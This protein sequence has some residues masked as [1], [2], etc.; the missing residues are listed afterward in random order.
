MLLM[1]AMAA[2]SFG[3]ITI[4][5]NVRDGQTISGIQAIRATV[6]SKHLITEVEFY[7]N[8]DLRSTDDSTPYE[9]QIDTIAE[10]EGP[11]K[12]KL[13]AFDTEGNRKELSLNLIV[14]NQV[15]KGAEFHVEQ[16]R[17]ALAE[18]KFDAAIQSGRVALKAQPKFIPARMLLAR[19]FFAQGVTDSAQKFIEDILVEQ[20]DNSEALDLKSAIALNG[21]FR[22]ST[23]TRE[24]TIAAISRALKLAGESRAKVYASRLEAFGKVTD[25]NRLQYVDLA[26]RASRFSLAISELEPIF[27]SNPQNSAVASRYLYALL[28][29]GRFRAAGDAATVYQRRGAPDAAGFALIAVIRQRQGDAEAALAAE[30][31]AIRSDSGDLTVRS[32]QMFLSLLRGR[33]QAFN[34]FTA[35]LAREE[36]QRFEVLHY[37]SAM[38]NIGGDFEGARNFFEQAVLAEPGS[39]DTFIQRANQLIAYSTSETSSMDDVRYY[40]SLARTL[41]EAALAA[42]PDSFEALTGMAILMQIDGKP[43]DAMRFAT[44]SANANQEY[45]A[46][47][48]LLGLLF[49][50]DSAGFRRA[51]SAAQGRAATLRANGQIQEANE[52][53]RQARE[54]ESQANRAQASSEQAVQRA[55]QLDPAQLGGRGIPTI[56]EAWRYFSIYGR[57]VFVIAPQ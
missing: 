7:V 33:A 45:A 37:L 42:R 44:A 4:N 32:S 31:E 25:A 17:A 49:S 2:L 11:I 51:A 18:R 55:N 47:Q 19:A 8:E 14:D 10:T 40:R 26:M 16:G 24:S 9:F 22:A 48:Y 34:Q 20:P 50:N 6:E 35:D 41:F 53:E 23:G 12:V 43:A 56:F 5:A 3:Q 15:S 1:S 54:L 29:A 52:A 30:A 39:Y 46:A 36:G 27:R 13:F 38:A 57:P 28:R 21:A